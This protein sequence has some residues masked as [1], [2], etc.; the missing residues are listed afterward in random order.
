MSHAPPATGSPDNAE[1]LGAP[2]LKALAAERE[3]HRAAEARFKAAEA[4]LK[5]AETRAAEQARAAAAA[6]ASYAQAAARSAV[7]ELALEH[8][9]SADH[10]PALFDA[11]DD[12]RAGIAERLARD[13]K[14]RAAAD[15][16]QPSAEVLHAASA[17]G[18]ASGATA[19]PAEQ[20]APLAPPAGSFDGGA[21]PFGR[22]TVQDQIARAANAGNW[23]K[24]S[25][26]NA[27]LLH[28]LA[29]PRHDAPPPPQ[30]VPQSMPTDGAS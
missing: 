21:Q 23:A 24:V 8:G 22:E 28:D 26:L 17:A 1:T 3:A 20:A 16:A 25:E 14:L 6:E 5:A 18:D 30:R 9:L 13:A 12:E 7:L 19:P 2:G 10:L 15:A 4:I 27:G 29:R 11:A